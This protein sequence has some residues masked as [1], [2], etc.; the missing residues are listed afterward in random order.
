MLSM[1]F[2]YSLG[3]IFTVPEISP[4]PP[5]INILM[6]G[7]VIFQYNDGINLVQQAVDS[8]SDNHPLMSRLCVAMGIGYSLKAQSTKLQG[9]RYSLHKKALDTF[10]R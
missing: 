10:K 1:Y 8:C 3:Y 9:E 5:R 6:F 4:I 7:N 2:T